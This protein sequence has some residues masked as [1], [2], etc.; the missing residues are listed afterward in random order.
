MYNSNMN[1]EF[2]P[3][4]S[5]SNLKKHGVDFIESQRL[6]DDPDRLVIPARTQDEARFLLIGKMDGKHWSAVFTPRG[7]KTRLISVR[8]A[9]EEEVEAYES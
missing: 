9:R 8:R 4:K 6:W 1:F 7:S 3:A 2:D 5:E